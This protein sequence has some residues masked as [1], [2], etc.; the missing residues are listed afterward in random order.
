MKSA[1]VILLVLAFASAQE[2][3][4]VELHHLYTAEERFHRIEVI[5]QVLEAELQ[6]YNK[7]FLTGVSPLLSQIFNYTK[8]YTD[9]YTRAYRL[10]DNPE[11]VINNVQDTQYYGDIEFGTPPQKFMAIFDTGS[12]NVWVPS[13]KCTSVACLLHPKYYSSQSS[14][15]VPDGREYKIKYGSGGVEGFVSKDTVQTAGLKATNYAFGEATKLSGVSFIAAKFESLVGMAFDKISVDD[16]PTFVDE[17]YR[18]GALPNKTFS[19][20]LTK[21][22]G[23]DGSALVWGGVNP[24]YY[25]GE[26]T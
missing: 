26:I 20:Y 15:Y 16:L 4:E 12:S 11:T 5:K 1:I 6:A 10:N 2:I 25:T 22:P 17:L 7:N 3:R 24:K 13:A 18:V 8:K 21:T 23:Q 9:M 19:F 14:T